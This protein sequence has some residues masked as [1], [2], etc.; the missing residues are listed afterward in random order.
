MKPIFLFFPECSATRDKGCSEG[1][2]K[3]HIYRKILAFSPYKARNY[4]DLREL[5]TWYK[6]C[7][8][9]CINYV[10]EIAKEV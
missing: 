7:I 3:C 4:K 6:I 1:V 5:I 10:T 9:I 2:K 8:K